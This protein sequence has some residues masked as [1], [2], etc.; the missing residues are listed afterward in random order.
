MLHE[1]RSIKGYVAGSVMIVANLVQLALIGY[2]K[3]MEAK[4][5]KEVLDK[6][7]EAKR[8]LQKYRVALLEVSSPIKHKDG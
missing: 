4:K 8:N 7:E 2:E 6:L 3:Y 1:H 5:W